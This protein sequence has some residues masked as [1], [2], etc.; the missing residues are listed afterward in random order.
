MRSDH[1]A[2]GA[3]IILAEAEGVG[4]FQA[5]PFRL[6]AEARQRRQHAAGKDIVADEVAAGAIA[7]E[8]FVRM[9]MVWMMARPPRFSRS[10]TVAKYC[11]Q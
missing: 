8:Q 3:R 10:A 6:L 4:E 11:G 2:Q 1:V 9:V 5:G 7:V